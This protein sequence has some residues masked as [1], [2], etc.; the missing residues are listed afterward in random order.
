MIQFSKRNNLFTTI[1]LVGFG[2]IGC[3]SAKNFCE[4]LTPY[5][6]HYIEDGSSLTVEEVRE[7]FQKMHGVSENPFTSSI[8]YSDKTHWISFNKFPN[9]TNPKIPAVELLLIDNPLLDDLIMYVFAEDKIQKFQSGD[10]KKFSKRRVPA[11]D[12]IFRIPPEIPAESFIL[13]VRSA[14]SIRLPLTK[15]VP[16]KLLEYEIENN[17]QHGFY[18]GSILLISIYHLFSFLLTKRKTFLMFSLYGITLVIFFSSNSGHLQKYFF[19]NIEGLSNH[20]LQFTNIL[21]IL[22]GLLFIVIFFPFFTKEK[23]SKYIIWLSY[24]FLAVHFL[25]VPWISYSYLSKIIPYFGMFITFYLATALFFKTNLTQAD[26]WVRRGLVILSIAI[27]IA[28]LRLNT[29]LPNVFFTLHIIKISQFIEV[30]FFALALSSQYSEMQK[31]TIRIAFEKEVALKLAEA[32]TDTLNY[33]SHEIR[34][35]LH[36]ITA[37]LEILGERFQ[38]DKTKDDIRY[39]LKSSDHVIKIVSD[40]LEQSRLEAG[41]IKIENSMFFLHDL[42]DELTGEIQPFL[43]QKNIKFF[44]EVDSN[45]P[46]EIYSDMFHI[47]QVLT[48]LLFNAFKFTKEGEVSIKV[49]IV[50]EKLRFQVIDS[51]KGI[52]EEDRNILF[53]KFEQGNQNLYKKF[54]GSGLGLMISRGILNL[55][56]SELQLNS[57]LG[58][59]SEFYFDLYPFTNTTQETV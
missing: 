52:T 17:I 46:K 33:L 12:H 3:S 14:G 32:K 28:I 40:V 45:V 35:P 26:L 34:N 49:T 50:D 53:T 56:G 58:V 48:N 30:L 38:D 54:G 15:C 42:L 11:T 22:F 16:G 24:L 7:K 1:L 27:I 8:G 59:G 47:H 36:S 6:L 41:K 5:V 10:Q 39:L 29:V 23:H 4:D 55:M 21:G 31:N 18:Y 43:V 57:K 19:P 37:Y 51:G 2:F 25:L 9:P 44:T 13:R 20:I